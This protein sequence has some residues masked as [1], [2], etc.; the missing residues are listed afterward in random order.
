MNRI[1]SMIKQDVEVKS[2]ST[3]ACFAVAK[4]TVRHIC[5]RPVKENNQ[6]ARNAQK[7]VNSS[8]F[9][10]LPPPFDIYSLQQLLVADLTQR[11]ARVMFDES[12]DT[13]DYKDVGKERR[14]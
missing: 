4:A 11:G 13:L 10:L 3:E 6:L 8:P 12:R 14:H 7:S 2:I 5:M 9:R 1:K